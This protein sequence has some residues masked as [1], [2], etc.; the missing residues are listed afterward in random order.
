M[1]RARGAYV[2]FLSQDAEPADEFWLE[3]LLDGF[4]LAPD[5][6]VV[7]GPYLPRRG[8]APAVRFELERWFASLAPDGQPRVERLSARERQ[9]PHE[10]GLSAA[11]LMGRRGFLTDVNACLARHA[12]ERVPFR[13]VPYAEDRVLAIDM[14]RAGFAKA[15]LPEAG[16]LHSHSYTPS[17]ELR[18]CF[19]E[20][21]GLLEVFGWREPLSAPY[22]SRR[23][24][25]ALTQARRQL[26]LAGA[27]PRRR[28]ATITAVGARELVR[29]VGALLGSR[30]DRLPASVRRRLSLESRASF[31]PLDLD[32]S[33][34]FS[35][36]MR[37]APGTEPTHAV[38]L[39]QEQPRR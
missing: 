27:P 20:W 10:G 16:V 26:F 39:V 5:V 32:D 31:T 18:R 22:L 37:G 8:A 3:R 6:G 2:A 14:L 29:M 25:G 7:Y 1:E 38:S 4:R 23:L 17:E 24:R 30:A 33:S 28:R 35:S 11:T 15:F 34:T 12:F 21:R 19:D 36:G 9:S 13:D